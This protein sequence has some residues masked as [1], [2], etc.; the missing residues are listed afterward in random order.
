MTN[1]GNEMTVDTDQAIEE[2]LGRASPRPVPPEAAAAAIRA[3]VRAEWRR[4]SGRRRRQTQWVRFAVA[5][6]VLIAVFSV[7]NTLRMQGIEPQQ[8]ASIG[9]RFGSVF[10]L[11]D[12]AEL[13]DSDRLNTIV[14]G[15]TLVTGRDSG[16]GISWGGGGSLRLDANTRVE[17]LSRDRIYL[18]SGRVY[19]DSAPHL[20]GGIAASAASLTIATTFG[21]VS[22]VGTQYMAEAGADRLTVSVRDGE[23]QIRS[24]GAVDTAFRL[25]QLAISGS[26]VH[27]V[28]N[29][30]PYG[31]TWQWVERTTPTISLDGR[32]VSEFLDWVA[33]E[34]GLVVR[35]ESDGAAETARRERLN[36]ILDIGPRQA[37]DAWMLGTDLEWRI[38][39][40]EIYVE[41]AP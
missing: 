39:N 21:E 35:Y 22:H 14:A 11:G 29:V 30:A 41:R 15:E 40:G 17:F 24:G 19:F 33:H 36:G 12:N 2:V 25:Q 31:E 3:A 4:I 38:A 32:T 13:L 6:S 18:H 16:L 8:V 1:P 7:L 10:V 28:V 27:S 34:T 9:K 26:G 23:V 5:A 37:L 20:A